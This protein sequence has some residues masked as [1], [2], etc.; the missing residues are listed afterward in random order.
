MSA[1]TNLFE[2]PKD[3]PVRP[4]VETKH[5]LREKKKKEKQELATYKVEQAIALW[6]PY[7]N[8][9]S[10]SDPYKTLF[11]ANLNYDTTESRLRREFE[12]YGSIRR[13]TFVHDKV[14]GKPRGYAFIEFKRE[15]EMHDAYK[16]ADGKRIDGRRVLVDV[17]RGRTQKGWLPRRLGGGLGGRKEKPASPQEP[18]WTSR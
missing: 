17:E 7:K 14:R 8:P 2:D 13:I 15:K 3:T 9:D 6:D 11:V 4:K 12:V 10:K 1:Y 5:E 16:K 18:S